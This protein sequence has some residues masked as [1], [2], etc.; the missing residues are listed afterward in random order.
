MESNLASKKDEPKLRV[1]G[2]FS[3]RCPKCQGAPIFKGFC[4]MHKK[5]P[6]CGNVYEKESGY[7]MGAMMAAYFLGI[8]AVMPTL[9]VCLFVFE[10]SI[11]VS[12]G[13]A[14]LQLILLQP[15]L[16][17]YSRIVWINT[18]HNLNLRA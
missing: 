13:V 11:P 4:S 5:C 12:I 8:I 7:F 1:T 3:N 9:V 17:Q 15:L 2:F 6:G 10:L 18:E 16:F 14:A